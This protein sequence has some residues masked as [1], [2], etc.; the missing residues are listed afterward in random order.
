MHPSCAGHHCFCRCRSFSFL[1]LH[2]HH[3]TPEAAP[4][5]PKT[6]TAPPAIDTKP[7]S[8]PIT[9]QNNNNKQ[10]NNNTRHGNAMMNG[11]SAMAPAGTPT[12]RDM[13]KMVAQPTGQEEMMG[14]WSSTETLAMQETGEDPMRGSPRQISWVLC[15]LERWLFGVDGFDDSS[16]FHPFLTFPPAFSH[17]HFPASKTALLPPTPR[18]RTHRPPLATSSNPPPSYP[19]RSPPSAFYLN[20]NTS[21]PCKPPSMY[22]LRMGCSSIRMGL[23]KGCMGSRGRCRCRGIDGIRGSRGWCKAGWAWGWGWDKCRGRRLWYVSLLSFFHSFHSFLLAFFWLTSFSFPRFALFRPGRFQRD[24]HRRPAPTA[25]ANHTIPRRWQRLAARVQRNHDC[26]G[27]RV[28]DGSGGGAV[29]R[30]WLVL[31]RR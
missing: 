22:R 13:R 24:P 1:S 23:P 12:M 19:R 25:T 21:T 8:R 16:I 29:W 31:F 9:N 2:R 30:D 26:S 5:E 17:L 14:M 4:T 11:G 18:P 15:S 10:P 3:Q 28:W 27:A 6:A 20:N 7:L